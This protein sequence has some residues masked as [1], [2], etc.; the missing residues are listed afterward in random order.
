MKNEKERFDILKR[1]LDEKNLNFIRSKTVINLD[2]GYELFGEYTIQKTNNRYA[3]SKYYT[4][5]DISFYSLKNAV[6]WVTMHKRNKMHDTNRIFQLDTLLESNYFLLK[7]NTALIK[8][9]SDEEARG[10]LVAK[11]S[12]SQAKISQINE[13]LYNYTEEVK[14]WQFKLF[15]ELETSVK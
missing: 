7:N 14:K 2:N 10:I 5:L 12:E 11:I 6:L 9:K 1:L 4:A 13:N 8:K 3:V 15:K